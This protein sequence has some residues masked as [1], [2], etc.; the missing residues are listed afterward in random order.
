MKKHFLL[1]LLL[2]LGSI[3]LA[4]AQSRQ[5]KGTVKS[6]EGETLP[7]VTVL[8]EGTT[9]GAST[10][11]DG[12]YSITL[13]T[14]SNNATIRFS[15][16]GYVSQAIKVGSQSTINVTLASD[17]K[18]LDDVVV[19]GF[20]AVERKD[21]TGSVSSVGAQQIKDIPVNSAAEALA[22]RLAGVQV[23]A[24]EGSPGA[25]IRI[26]VRGGG[27]VTQD[28][29]PLYVVDGVQVENALSVLSPQDI[30]SIDVLKDASATAIY[31][32]R[33]ANGVVIITTKNGREG[34]T[35][36]AYNGFM[37][38]RKIARTL[39]VLKPADYLDYAYERSA[40]AGSA[41]LSTFKSRY[42]TSNFYSDTLNQYK[43]A[44]F[45][46]WQDRVFGRN[47]LYQTHNVSVSGGT[48]GTTYNLSLTNNQEEGIQQSSAFVRNLVSFRFDHQASEKFR[49]GFNSRFN[50]QVISGN[51][52][53]S[54][55]STTTSRLRSAVQ[56]LPINATLANG[57]S[58]GDDV[59]DNDFFST[60]AQLINPLVAIENEYKRDRRR[61]FNISGYASYNFTKNLAFRSTAGFDNN[62]NRVETFYGSQSPNVFGN[63]GGQPSA[64]IAFSAPITFNNSNVLTYRYSKGQH[65][66]DGVIGQ[67]LYIQNTQTLSIQT[68]YLPSNITP[69]KAINNIN[70]GVLPS[71][72]AL[73]PNPTTGRPIDSRLLSGFG[74]VNY[75]FADKYL[76]TATFRAD[77]SS[78]F[79]E[80]QRVGYFPAASVAWRVSS[81]EF[82]KSFK[83][84]TD[85]KLRASYGLS[86]NN[87]ISDFL[88]DTYFTSGA[89]YAMNHT[90]VNGVSAVALANPNLKW[91]T[92]A[93][94]N[95]G[96]D[97]A[98]FDNRLQLT[99][100][101]YYN[102]TSDLLLNLSIPSTS[103]YTTQLA[104]V[105]STSNR[106]IELQATGT[107]IRTP[108][109]SWTANANISFNRN[110]VENLGGGTYPL[111][112]S[113]WASTAI[114]SDYA[115]RVGEPVGL[116]YGYVTD[117]FYTTAD[118]KGYDTTTKTWILKDGVA[119]DATVIGTAVSPGQ[120]KLKDLD[121]SGTVN[122]TDRQVIG[123][124]NPKNTGGL[125][126][127][128]SYK[129][130]DASIFMNWS[131]G[132][133]VWNDNKIEYTTY[134]ANSQFANGLE[135]MKDRYRTIDL[136]TGQ[137]IT[138]IAQLDALNQNATIWAA[139]RQLIPHSWAVEDASFLR[140]NN[141]TIGYTLPKALIQHA[142]LSQF[143]IYA[144]V[145]N[146]YT[147]T[148]YTGF[149][150]EVNTRRGSP[151]TPGVDYAG[152]PRSKAYLVGV[153]L[154]F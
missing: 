102:K 112:Y 146:I 65:K 118:F 80:G 6:A 60:S 154:S 101:A 41:G 108:D 145:N 140:I 126:Q 23:T 84:I 78:K 153:N 82:M 4:A 15:Y 85:L 89:Q 124:A 135:I 24:S 99:A 29:S 127:Q 133:N 39:D 125:N 115:V 40:Q 8:V 105:G 45:I 149:D 50:D 64:S 120:L 73:Q 5:I 11:A 123:N 14:G 16:V 32:A 13:P 36:V 138:D 3:G 70:Q 46:N 68:N 54:S 139:P 132:N 25:D 141:V 100:D 83:Q 93:S 33:G 74:R 37:G 77:G 7:G 76:F 48:K 98:L 26:R 79:A 21:V 56:Y 148:K 71:A 137:A 134:L 142:K 147:F 151:L 42:G 34:K 95:L 53:S 97:I 75:S 94:T 55:G 19:I 81:E 103:G 57:I 49:L 110:R 111:Q 67:E 136:K 66:F 18:Q 117:G 17:S 109:F 28:N 2:L 51:G 58:P 91:E 96:L 61:L 131:Y 104:N 122:E 63:L 152:Y 1:L 52:T 22:G 119:N 59:V 9:N 128:F 143:R 107:I 116:M 130:F 30:Q 87:R 88:Y 43:N 35:T 72:T 12:D 114:S 38:I 150:P 10:G 92:T 144:T 113:G 69:E 129:G 86:G 44:P 106:G 62:N 20:Q 47:A 27:S 31:G 121:G 90:I